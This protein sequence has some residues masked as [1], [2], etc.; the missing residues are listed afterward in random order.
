L[1][2]LPA[3]GKRRR[4]VNKGHTRHQATISQDPTYHDLCTKLSNLVEAEEL[5]LSVRRAIASHLR[6]TV[7]HKRPLTFLKSLHKSPMTFGRHLT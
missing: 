7:E 6:Y 4:T 5:Y 2:E 3:T 1:E